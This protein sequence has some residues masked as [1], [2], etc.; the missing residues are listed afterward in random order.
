VNLTA[1]Q[2]LIIP[3]VIALL[4]L[5]VIEVAM[6]RWIRSPS[7]DMRTTMRTALATTMRA[8]VARGSSPARASRESRV[9]H[10]VVSLAMYVE[11]NRSQS[12]ARRAAPAAP[13]AA[14]GRFGHADHAAADR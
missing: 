4:V 10:D 6:R 1:M 7:N 12:R 2:E 9:P 3:L 14:R 5:S 11:R 13:T 8:H